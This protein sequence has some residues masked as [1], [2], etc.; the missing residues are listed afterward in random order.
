MATSARRR[1]GRTALEIVLVI[2][3]AVSIMAGGF[4][5]WAKC[6]EQDARIAELEKQLAEQGDLNRGAATH[7][8]RLKAMEDE[9][10]RTRSYEVW[11]E[12]RVEVLWQDYLD[13][14]LDQI[15]YTCSQATYHKLGVGLFG[16]EPLSTDEYGPDAANIGLVE[17]SQCSDFDASLEPTSF[18]VCHYT[19]RPDG[20]LDRL[21]NCWFP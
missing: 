17:L 1:H 15:A 4:F 8:K 9:A 3:V 6:T 13:R 21:W 12:K 10:L 11:T 19:Q 16:T 18:L 7:E 20:S 5:L 2:L 14:K